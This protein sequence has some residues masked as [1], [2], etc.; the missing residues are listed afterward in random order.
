MM[1]SKKNVV[2]MLFSL[3]LLTGGCGAK[4][5]ESINE[6]EDENALEEYSST[7]LNSLSKAKKARILASLPAIRLQINRF[8]Q[9]QGRYPDSLEDLSLP[10]DIPRAALD[11]S[12]ETGEVSVKQ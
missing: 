12:A 5:H 4:D 11:Y 7:L 2:I 1:V 10:P 8:Q 3:V 9:E 6:P